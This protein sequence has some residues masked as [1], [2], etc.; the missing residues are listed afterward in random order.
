MTIKMHQFEDTGA[1]IASGTTSLP[2]HPGSGRNWDYRYCWLR[3][4]YF[5]LA[6]LNSLGHFEEAENY[7]NFLQNIL[8][9]IKST[10]FI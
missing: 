6:A 2:E 8:I 5:S 10:C 3:D 9:D 1:I 4:S 7:L